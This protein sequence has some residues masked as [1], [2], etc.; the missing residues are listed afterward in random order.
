MTVNPFGALSPLQRLALQLQMP[1][2]SAACR[3]CELQLPLFVTDELM[4]L[5]VDDLYPQ[6]AVHLDIC[7][8]CLTEYL[9]L[10]HMAHDALNQ[11]EDIL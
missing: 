8:D 1:D 7:P 2:T 5:A 6:T 10:V 3:A 11:D 9:E 4:G